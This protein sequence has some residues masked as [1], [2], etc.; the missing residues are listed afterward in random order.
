MSH[1]ESPTEHAA[2]VRR[3]REQEAHTAAQGR[4]AARRSSRARAAGHARA[5]AGRVRART[6]DHLLARERADVA[7]LVAQRRGELDVL[8]R[9]MSAHPEGI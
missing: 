1:R 3:E 6:L 5:Q 2:R 8:H 9:V 4:K 7:H